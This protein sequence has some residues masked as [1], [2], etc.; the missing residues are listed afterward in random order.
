MWWNQS[1]Q[2][3]PKDLS[4]H[5][6]CEWV[7]SCDSIWRIIYINLVNLSKDKQSSC[8][9]SYA[10]ECKYKSLNLQRIINVEQLDGL[11]QDFDNS[12]VMFWSY[13]SRVLHPWN[14]MTPI[15]QGLYSILLP[16][17]PSNNSLSVAVMLP[18]YP[19]LL[20]TNKKMSGNMDLISNHPSN[21][22][23]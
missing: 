23:E 14:M 22:T 1:I 11:A 3:K 20:W 15:F 16:V 19:W 9:K 4:F 21:V 12:I 10:W 13:C 7:Y 5:K 8:Q 17:L 6:I 18:D 2:V